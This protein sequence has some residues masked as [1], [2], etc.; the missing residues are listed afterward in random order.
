[1]YMY[2]Y[3]YMYRRTMV[4]H[5]HEETPSSYISL[6]VHIRRCVDRQKDGLRIDREVDRWIHR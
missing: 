3:V 5:T 1:M 6:H 2:I 4:P